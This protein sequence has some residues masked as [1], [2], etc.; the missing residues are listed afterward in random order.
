M[1]HSRCIST[2]LSCLSHAAGVGIEISPAGKDAQGGRLK[3]FLHHV[4]VTG[5]YGDSPA[6]VKMMKGLSHAAYMGCQFC[7]FNGEMQHRAMRFLGYAAPAVVVKGLGKAML[8]GQEGKALMVRDDAILQLSSEEQWVRAKSF[9]EGLQAAEHDDLVP[10]DVSEVGVS[11]LSPFPC[12]LWYS[13]YNALFVMPIAH[14]LYRGVV[15]DFLC[16]I[17]DGQKGKKKKQGKGQMGQVGAGGGGEGQE[18][19]E[20]GEGEE[21]GEEEGER[22]LAP[23]FICPEHTLSAAERKRMQSRHAALRI[24]QDFGGPVRCLDPSVN[25]LLMEELIR[26]MDC[27]IPLMF[28]EVCGYMCQ[29]LLFVRLGC[30][31]RVFRCIFRT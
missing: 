10:P 8:T 15:R 19:G 18:G 31:I 9:E 1:A 21:E 26:Q 29:C 14:M 12:M 17:V 24:T 22:K 28:A 23:P 25:A 5:V 13:D 20:E 4:V 7:L 11:G 6:R 30:V 3:K 27:V 16:A 2:Q